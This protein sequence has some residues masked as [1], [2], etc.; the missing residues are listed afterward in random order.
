MQMLHSP[1]HSHI[2]EAANVSPTQVLRILLALEL[3]LQVL[4]C[5]KHPFRCLSKRTLQPGL[6]CDS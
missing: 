1:T 2:Y 4:S 5:N 3:M 6:E